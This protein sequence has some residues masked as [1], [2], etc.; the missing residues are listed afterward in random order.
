MAAGEDSGGTAGEGLTDPA[1][2][3]RLAGR[4][5]L[6]TAG[7][8]REPID[9]VRF[10]GNR[11]SG[12]QGIALAKAALARGASV[13]LIAANLEPGFG[14]DLAGLDS[15]R[16][17]VVR[18]A[19]AEELTT[20]LLRL[21]PGFDL[22][23][24]AA[25]V[26]DYRPAVVE[27]RKI[28]K[29]EQGAELSLRLVQTADALALVVGQRNPEQIVVGFAAETATDRAELLVLA[30]GKLA[31]KGCHFLVAND[32]TAGR[33]FGSASNEVLVVSPDGLVAEAAGSKEAVAQ[34]ILDAITHS[35]A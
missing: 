31:A 11:S 25:A 15:S 10:I 20:Q 24:C 7:G 28:K 14:T 13:T 27:E 9:A 5:V 16:L 21:A 8:T 12:R 30:R 18:V 34:A 32:V 2:T 3:L 22:V 33:G 17:D 4:S 35:L 6:I 26:A 23:I 19:T 1:N 29:S